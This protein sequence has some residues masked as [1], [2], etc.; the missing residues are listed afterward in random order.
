MFVI[1]VIDVVNILNEVLFL[2]FIYIYIVYKKNILVSVLVKLG[3]H[4]KLH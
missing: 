4:N 2:D 3:H 1:T